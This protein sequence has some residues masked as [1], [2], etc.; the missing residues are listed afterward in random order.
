MTFPRS[1]AEVPAHSPEQ[2][3]GV[4]GVATYSEKLEVGYRWYDAQNVAPLFPFGFG[5][6]YTSFK[7]SGLKV[8][9]SG[10]SNATVEL[11]VSNTGKVF[12]AEVV[13]VYVGFPGAAGEPPHQL[14]G[15]ARVALAPRKTQ[16]VTIPL[17]ARAF[18]IWDTS[19]NKWVVFN[20]AYEVLVGDSSRDLPLRATIDIH[21]PQGLETTAAQAALLPR[22]P[23]Q[24]N[25]LED[26][27]K[28]INRDF[29]R[30]EDWPQLHRYAN[31]NAVLSGPKPRD[32]RVVFMGDSITDGWK[33][34]EY[35]PG[36]DYVDRGI[37]GQTTPQMLDRMLPDVIDLEP[38]VVIILAGTNDIAGNTGPMTLPEIEQNYQAMAELA[39]AHN[40]KVIFESVL[41]I[42]DHGVHG[43]QSPRRSPQQISALNDW[44]KA[45]CKG[46]NHIYLD[47]YTHMLG[48]DGMLRTDLS[49]D[50][51]HPN[52]EGYKIMAPLAE[53][54]IEQALGENP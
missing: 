17:D 4:N 27:Q 12:G 24:P 6:S 42:H 40:I 39:A 35:F 46:H 3:P 18:S 28:T 7:L 33:L 8:S 34:P 29:H 54:A 9:P 31:A 52:A 21:D 25:S 2:Y 53:A 32:N 49:N 23:A 43:P 14:K 19:A 13:Q 30:L 41:P 5:L 20:G 1:E 50:G 44:L 16:H 37:S 51:L 15:F 45:Y 48:P 22:R 10:T 11:D 38:K 36:K 47:Y 26:A